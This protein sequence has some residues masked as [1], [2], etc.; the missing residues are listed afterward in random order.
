MN[1]TTPQISAEYLEET[2]IELVRIN[3]INP[4]LSAE[5][6]G[7]A[8]ISAY[9]AQELKACGMQVERRELAPGRYNVI[10]VRKGSG[11]G[12]SLIWNAHMDTVGSNGMEQPFKPEVRAGRLY[13]RGSQDMKGSLA[14]MLAAARALENDQVQLGGDVIFA[15]VG[16]EEYASLGTEDLVRNLHADA[17]LVLEPTELRICPAHRG[18]ILYEVETF[19]KAAHGSR[20]M[21]GIDAIL[22]MG[23][24]LNGLEKLADE[25]IGRPAHPLAGPPSLHAS[26][27]QG[28]TEAS[29]Y[30]AYCRLEL[31]R[32]TSPGESI[33]QASAEIQEILDGIA[34]NDG[35]FNGRLRSTISRPAFEIDPKEEIVVCLSQAL[36]HHL[37]KTAIIGGATF[38]TDAAL[39]AEAG[40][41]CVVFGPSGAGL[42]S[43]EEW[44]DL[45]SCCDVAQ[46]LAQTTLDFCS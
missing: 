17:G 14:A 7:E 41:P 43:A 5:G 39:L 38:W 16:D 18:F 11:G 28:G 4:D 3:S 46:V 9:I 23:R 15:G 22:H 29:T 36:T 27:I 26:I 24:F 13:G 8:Q 2:L 21:D 6:V 42:H 20:Y 31:E 1:K 12:K 33:E 10:G 45:Q 32:R 25:L 40:I 34:S 19:G 35:K 37:G 30:P 44:V